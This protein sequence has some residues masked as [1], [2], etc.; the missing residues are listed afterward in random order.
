MAVILSALCA[1]YP[2]IPG[3]FLVLIS[4]RGWIDLRA[5][6]RL[7]GLGKL[8]NQSQ[9]DS[10]PD[11]PACRIVPQSTTLALRNRVEQW[12]FLC[13][14][15]PIRFLATDFKTGTLLHSIHHCTTAHEVFK[16]HVKS[17][18]ADFWFFFCY[19]LPVAISHENWLVAPIVFKVTPLHG[20]HGN[21]VFLC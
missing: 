16:S 19:E 7:E 15:F 9:R 18:Q 2:L 10:N 20:P 1:G 11:L 3:R 12:L 17:S 5:I 13:K 4:A 6:V 21:T 8:K 14:V